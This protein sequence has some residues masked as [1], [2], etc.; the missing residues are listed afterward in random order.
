[1]LN[2]YFLSGF[3]MRS[4]LDFSTFGKV[5]PGGW[6]K[7][8]GL[9][10]VYDVYKKDLKSEDFLVGYLKHEAQHFSD[11]RKFPELKQSVLEYRAKLVE[12]I[13][14][15]DHRRLLVFLSGAKNDSVLPHQQAE[16]MITSAL[17]KRF[18]NSKP[19]LEKELWLGLPYKSVSGFCRDLFRKSTARLTSRL[20]PG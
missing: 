11:N 16:Y 17:S 3:L 2:V 4:W 18:F 20:K 19:P 13:Y 15:A 12:L 7:K 14:R 9:Y 5:G 6:A 10:C 1:M 8:E